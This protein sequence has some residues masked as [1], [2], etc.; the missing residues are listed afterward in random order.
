MLLLGFGAD[1]VVDEM[2]RSGMG[3]VADV[4]VLASTGLIGRRIRKPVNGPFGAFLGLIIETMMFFHGVYFKVDVAIY[5][6]MEP[7]L[8][9]VGDLFTS[10]VEFFFISVP[11]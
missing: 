5:S 2:V 3:C 8:H 1:V 10:K 7:T 6:P 11:A 4:V 9:P